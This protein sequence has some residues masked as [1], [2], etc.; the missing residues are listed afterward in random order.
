MG[1][2]CEGMTD[3]YQAAV[4]LCVSIALMILVR[5]GVPE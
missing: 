2:I 5:R 1:L 4:L 3:N